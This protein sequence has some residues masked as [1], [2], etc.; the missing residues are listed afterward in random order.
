M[1]VLA[2]LWTVCLIRLCSAGFWCCCGGGTTDDND[3]PQVTSTPPKP[4]TPIT[5]DLAKPDESHINVEEQNIDGVLLKDYLPKD[6]LHISSVVDGDK[7]LWK[8]SGD[9]KCVFVESYSKGALELLYLET[10]ES[11]GTK[12]KYFEK[13]DG[14][15]NEIDEEP[16]N[17]KAKTF[18][19]ESGRD[20]SLNIAHPSRLLCQSFNYTFAANAVQLIVPNKGV[21]VSKLVNNTETVWTAEPG[22]TFD[23]AKVYL[24]KDKKPELVLLVTTLSGTPKETYLELKDGKWV[25][26]NDKDAKMKNLKDT[27][28]WKSDFEL[29][30]SASKDTDKCRIFEAELLGVTTRHFYPKP[31]HVPI[32][33]Q[34]GNKE[35]W[36]STTCATKF[37]SNSSDSCLSCL[38]YEKG[39]IKILEMITVERLT[40]RY[41]YFER[42]SGEAWKTITEE[43]FDKK[44]KDMRNGTANPAPKKPDTSTLAPTKP[45]GN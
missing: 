12:Y 35:L 29:D 34:D 15:W 21:S 9:E 26:C 42:V 4:S 6:D 20:A 33:V 7:E 32:K 14:K 40:K 11:S 17:E 30:L 5:L 28:E 43:D 13:T 24:N 23:H 8:A 36:K 19:G 27:T 1:R 22:E 31:G 2:I 3:P 39:D 10:S 16:F 38:I 37:G 44:L 41:N 25:S 45:S 18:I